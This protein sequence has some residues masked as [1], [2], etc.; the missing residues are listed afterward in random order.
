MFKH[1]LICQNKREKKSTVDLI[2]QCRRSQMDAME[3][4]CADSCK[5]VHHRKGLQRSTRL[6]GTRHYVNSEHLRDILPPS[7][8]HRIGPDSCRVKPRR[9]DE[10]LRRDV[11]PC[12]LRGRAN[13]GQMQ[14]VGLLQLV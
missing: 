9:R 7:M 6:T 5:V 13:A 12:L 8:T 11:F 10:E 1:S 2:K 14:R 4:S 3:N